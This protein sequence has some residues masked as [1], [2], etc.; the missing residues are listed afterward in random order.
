MG[1]FRT[2]HFSQRPAR[3]ILLAL[4]M[5][6]AR[7]SNASSRANRSAVARRRARIVA[8]VESLPELASRKLATNTSAL[9]LAENGSATISIVDAYRLTAPNRLVAQL[10]VGPLGAGD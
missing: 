1:E 7:V 9:R 8:L 6:V 2:P 3:G 10:D 4:T 5:P